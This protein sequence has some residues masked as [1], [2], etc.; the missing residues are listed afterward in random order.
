MDGLTLVLRVDILKFGGEMIKRITIISL[1]L[2]LISLSSYA[3][4]S[5]STT[6]PADIG[7]GARPLG[8]GKA[9]VGNSG[10]ANSLFINP[11]GLANIK[12]FKGNSM[13]GQV[14]E[15][16]SYTVIDGAVPSDWGTIGIGYISVNLPSIPVTLVTGTGTLAAVVPIGSTNYHA[17]VTTLSYSNSASKLPGLQDFDNL[18]Y[19]INLKYFDQGFVG[20]GPSMEGASGTG[21]DID[22]GLQYKVS[23]E[24]TIGT[25]VLNALPES[26]GGVFTWDKGGVRENIPAVAQVGG[27]AKLFGTDSY[28]G[29][30]QNLYLGLQANAYPTETTKLTDY[31][32][33]VEWWP[34]SVMAIRLGIDQKPKGTENGVDLDNNY[35][36]GIGLKASGFTFDYCYHQYSD[37]TDNVTHFFSIGYVGIDEQPKPDEKKRVILP[38]IVSSP[39]LESF[40]DVPDGYWAKSPIQFMATL[41]I[42]NGFHDGKFRP[43]D[44]VSRSE[45]ASMLVRLKNIEANEVVNDPYPDVSKDYWAA[46]YI[47]AVSYLNLMSNYPDGTF[48]PDKNVSRIEG[49]V[50][51][52]RLS[53]SASTDS[54]S[55][56]PFVDVPKT[57]WAARYIDTAKKTGLVDYLIG[58]SFDPN[59][60]LTRA[61]VAELLSK[62]SYGKDRIRKYL[63]SNS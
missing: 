32:A 44:P 33:G 48:K 45:F 30:N 27:T 55:K 43:D 16:I 56:D 57:H 54:P 1:S 50:S 49:V 42:M 19:G 41:G 13:T 58:K 18:T 51:L 14:L 10:D 28:F 61:E 36:A 40:N 20:G 24:L 46:R 25:C 5:G 6:D 47:K 9:F 52:A 7:V 38:V 23:K 4:I 39:S 60:E 53:E 34:I 26:L 8:L 3:A 2:L 29:T 21:F 59:R 22:L 15:D 62:T 17:T 35:T 11:A 63:Q 12:S 31:H 37:L